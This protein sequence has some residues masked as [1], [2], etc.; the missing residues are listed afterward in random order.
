[1]NYSHTSVSPRD[2][3][4]EPLLTLTRASHL[5]WLPRRRKGKAPNVATLWRWAKHGCFGIRLRT[6]SVGGSLCVTESDLRAF[7]AEITRA[8]GLA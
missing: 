3:E 5:P 4:Q 8:R 7:F 6:T 2:Q 1:M